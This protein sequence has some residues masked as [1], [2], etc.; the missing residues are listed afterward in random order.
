MPC[1]VCPLSAS[2]GPFGAG[3]L[4]DSAESALD[5]S[6]AEAAELGTDG[7]TGVVLPVP[8]SLLHNVPYCSSIRVAWSSFIAVRS[9]PCC[10]V[11]P[12]PRVVIPQLA[13]A[14]PE[15]WKATRPQS[16]WAW[17]ATSP[18]PGTP[19]VPDPGWVFNM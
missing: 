19:T 7:I 10:R 2:A 9:M 5:E 3:E 1:N 4:S 6:A 12:C 18:I 14:D 16:L 11:S 8:N 17:L 15:P 13:N